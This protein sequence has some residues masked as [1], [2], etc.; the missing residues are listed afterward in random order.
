MTSR[1]QFMKT[2][3]I[4]GIGGILASGSAP[5]FA[6]DMKVQKVGQIGLGSHSFLLSFNNPP[7]GFKGK[8]GAK[9]NGVWDD[10]PGVAEAMSARGYGKPYKDYVELTN[11]SDA[12]HIEHAD[13]RKVYELAQPALE[14]GK[15]VFINRPFAGTIADAQEI[16]RLA[17]AHDAPLMSASSLEFQPVIAD[18]QT[19]VKDKG[20]I[21]GYEAYCPEPHFTWH[22]PHVLNY[23]HAALGG[24]IDSA[25]FTGDYVMS[26]EARQDR[27]RKMGTSLIVLKYKPRGDE[28]PIIGMNHVGI[29]PGSYHIDIYTVRENR[30]FEAGTTDSSVMYYMFGTLNDFY[31][32]RKIPRPYDAILEQ[33]RTLVAANVS[34]LSGREVKLDSLGGGDSLPWSESIRR[35][36]I[37]RTLKK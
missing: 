10:E 25:Y 12:V 7:K 8:V 31:A 9:P 34:R 28:P 4:A 32:K 24:G 20:P 37:R 29:H 2:T 18:M 15:P 13:Y 27:V 17:K 16:V 19:F 6:Q 26:L 3:T 14:Q 1:R 5:A 11:E 22:F 36:L 30:L 33:H 23:A 21:R 35:W